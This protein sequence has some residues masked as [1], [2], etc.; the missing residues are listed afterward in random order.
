MEAFGHAGHARIQRLHQ[1]F[2]RS[3]C[4]SHHSRLPYCNKT[5]SRTRSRRLD[6]AEADP[7]RT[8]VV[9][10]AVA[11]DNV[12]QHFVASPMA[13]LVRNSSSSIDT[14]LGSVT[15]EGLLSSRI[16]STPACPRIFASV[17][18]VVPAPT[19]SSVAADCL[20]LAC[21]SPC[22]RPGEVR[23]SP[24]SLVLNRIAQGADTGDIDFY[25]VS[26]LHPQR[27]LAERARPT[28]LHSS[29]LAQRSR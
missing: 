18:P 19:I 17:K 7:A 21:L 14:A 29:L 26:R 9:V 25:D 5:G 24:A 10:D 16:V 8:C 2:C 3:Y 11:S 15:V 28:G 4:S 27:R 23:T 20:C 1:A 12:L 6:L 13:C 22:A